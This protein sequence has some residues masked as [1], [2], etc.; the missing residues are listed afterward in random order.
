MATLMIEPHRAPHR[1]CDCGYRIVDDL[2]A[3]QYH[4]DMTVQPTI[5]RTG[6][7]EAPMALCRV[8]GFGRIIRHGAWDDP[9]SAS[10]V[11]HMRLIGPIYLP[12]DRTGRAADRHLERFTP[13]PET[14]YAD[15]PRDIW[16][17][18]LDTVDA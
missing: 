1:D 7:I 2:D 16:T 10:R 5:Q 15:D 14:W 8:Q 13:R 11:S 6:A 9:P 12:D 18:D 3:L 17:R 4:F